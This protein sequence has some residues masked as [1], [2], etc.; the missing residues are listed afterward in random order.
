[1]KAPDFDY[2]RAAGLADVFDAFAHYGEEAQILA[3]GQS[4]LASL[5]LRLSQPAALIDINGLAGLAGIEDR[6][7]VVRIGA[8]TRHAAVA[9][10]PAVAR[11]LPLVARA[12]PHVAHMAVR[13]RGTFGGSIALADPAAEMPACLLALEGDLVLEGPGGRRTVAADDFFLGLYETALAP[14]EV[15]VEARLPAARPGEAFAFVELSRRHGD[16]ALA[17]IA[18]RAR[19]DAGAIHGLRLVAF[20]AEERPRVIVDAA[21][22]AEG[23]ALAD[24]AEAVAEAV[25]AAL[26]PMDSPLASAAYKRHLSRVL[27]A[28]AVAELA[29]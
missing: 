12:M 3:G 29:P 21:A 26:D 11:R 25:G 10:D 4:L 1:M 24:A 2:V 7:D 28:R 20:A 27:A 5:N 17:G 19:L 6:G 16:F 14:D 22:A 13:N 18:C 8:M 15:L 23:R 9:A